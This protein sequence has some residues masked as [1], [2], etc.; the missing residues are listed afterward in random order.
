MYPPSKS[1]Y[2]KMRKQLAHWDGDAVIGTTKKQAIL[3]MV[4]RK[5]GIGL[6]AKAASKMS[7]LVG[8]GIDAKL[9]P[10]KL[11]VK[12]LTIDNGER[13]LIPIAVGSEEATKTSTNYI[14]STFPRCD[15]SKLSPMTS[16]YDSK[17]IE[18]SAAESGC[19]SRP[20]GA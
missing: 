18:L 1:S 2:F 14:G 5:R 7:D 19:D 10:L 12:I 4:E 3:T 20:Y 17:Q 16:F 6:L 13:L 8:R 15:A 9:K 11:R